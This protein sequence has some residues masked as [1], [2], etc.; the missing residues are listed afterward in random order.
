MPRMKY[1]VFSITEGRLVPA[2]NAKRVP[3]KMLKPW[4][5]RYVWFTHRSLGLAC[6]FTMSEASTGLAVPWSTG[7]ATRTGAAVNGIAR[8]QA[9]GAKA[10][11]KV[12]AMGRKGVYR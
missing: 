12:V 1:K 4:M 8:L 10:T 11:R 7:S 2:R 3:A 9:A 6:G 5:R